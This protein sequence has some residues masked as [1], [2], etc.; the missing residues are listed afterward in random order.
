MQPAD[1]RHLYIHIYSTTTL[2]TRRKTS[3]RQAHTSENALDIHPQIFY[4]GNDSGQDLNKAALDCCAR[5]LA[6]PC[7]STNKQTRLVYTTQSIS[8]QDSQDSYLCTPYTRWGNQYRHHAALLLF[9]LVG[10]NLPFLYWL[11][12]IMCHE[13]ETINK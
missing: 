13:V 3:T 6:K 9:S 4:Y 5:Q 7:E 1:L 11:C 2:Y 8:E 12:I 10:F